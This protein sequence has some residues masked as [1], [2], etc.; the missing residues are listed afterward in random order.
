[1]ILGLFETKYAPSVCDLLLLGGEINKRYW[2]GRCIVSRF[3]SATERTCNRKFCVMC[4]KFRMEVAFGG[5][6]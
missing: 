2:C 1:M 6:V 5:I 4:M 3:S